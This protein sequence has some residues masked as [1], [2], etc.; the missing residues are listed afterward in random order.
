MHDIT[1]WSYA[2]METIFASSNSNISR[3]DFLARCMRT[4]AEQ[5]G[6]WIMSS[7]INH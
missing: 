3:I 4:N 7:Q 2:K 5:E 1:V 6:V